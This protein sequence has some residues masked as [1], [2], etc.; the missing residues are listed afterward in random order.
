[1]TTVSLWSCMW[2]PV[3]IIPHNTVITEI[4]GV[5]SVRFLYGWQTSKEVSVR[6][7]APFQSRQIVRVGSAQRPE[8]AKRK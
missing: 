3:P 8:P 2:L 1:M 7:E 6:K 4:L 5:R